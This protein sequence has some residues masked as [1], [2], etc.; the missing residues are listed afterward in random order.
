MTDQ[1][2]PDDITLRDVLNAIFYPPEEAQEIRLPNMSLSA[3]RQRIQPTDEP[4]APDLASTQPAVIDYALADVQPVGAVNLRRALIVGLGTVANVLIATFAQAALRGSEAGSGALLLACLT[5][6]VWISLLLFQYAIPDEGLLRRGPLVIGSAGWPLSDWAADLNGLFLRVVL[7]VAG[8]GLCL[9]T[10]F[11]T[12]DNL[13]RPAGV[14]AWLLSI[15]MWMTA[16]SERDPFTLLIDWRSA[17]P[18]LPAQLRSALKPRFLP[19]VAFLLIMGTAVFFRV[20]RLDAIPY[21]MTSDHVEKLLDSYDVSQGIYHVFFT[22]NGGR[23]AIQFYLVPLAANLFGTGIS[24]LTLKLVSVLE[25]LALIPLMILLGREVV[26]RETGF[27]AAALV[28]VSWWHIALSRLSLR[29]VLT[30]FL[31]T[32]VLVSLI[33]GIR[34]GQRRSWLW[35]G[36][37]MGL[38]VYG[39]Q[40]M[41]IV[42][43]V[44]LAAALVAVVGPAIRAAVCSWQQRPDAPRRWDLANNVASRQAVN[45]LLA[46]VVALAFFVPM[47]RV[48]HDYPDQLWARV[49]N[50]TTDNEV[51]IQGSATQV[52]ADNFADALRMFNV[53]GD[54]AWISAVPGEPM[55]ST[56]GGAL[57]LLGLAAWAVRLALRRDPVDAFL[58]LAGLIMLLPSALAIAFPIE[59]PSTTRAS[60]SLPI[61]FLLAAWPL[62]LIRQKW[63]EVMGRLPGLLFSGLLIGALLA[64]AAL[65]NF[66]AYFTRYD[67]SYRQSALNPGPVADA[68]RDVIGPDAP[69]DGVWLVGWPFWHDYRA[70]GIEAGDITFHNAVVDTSVLRD[71]LLNFPD[72]F[73]ARPLVFIVH[74]DDEAT[75]DL[76]FE[77]FP[78]GDLQFHRDPVAGKDFYLFVV[79]DG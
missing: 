17:L 9:L 48:W 31:I 36:F 65:Y 51:N 12:A 32:L 77:W 54:V 24:F 6:I 21:Q 23:E 27:W 33:R 29:I 78:S 25:G 47:L 28:A 50:R 11:L 5:W 56:V 16:L 42:P 79:T 46:G 10:Y 57:F 19:I 68:I 73:A 60:G 38:G 4:D 67:Q 76:L 59:N 75:V 74:P 15:A 1:R 52:L 18:R 53:R 2:S 43:V 41:R 30:P 61:V 49:I 13:F 7:G 35:A 55:F 72:P 20:Y 14:A 40:A 63:T 62:S 64:G 71:Y 34:T 69:L 44:A 58:V 26:D 66:D 45:L 22:R 39:Y 8:L 3:I 37:W 70:I